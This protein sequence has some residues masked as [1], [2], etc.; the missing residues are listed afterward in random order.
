MFYAFISVHSLHSHG[1][2]KP[3][4]IAKEGMETQQH[5]QNTYDDATRTTKVMKD[6]NQVSYSRSVFVNYM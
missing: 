3:K 5:L 2:E 6:G 1:R 4:F